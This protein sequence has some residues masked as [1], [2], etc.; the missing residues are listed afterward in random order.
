[1][2]GQQDGEHSAGD[3]PCRRTTDAT[4]IDMRLLPTAALLVALITASP[5]GAQVVQGLVVDD[6]TNR[7]IPGVEVTLV[8]DLLV[9]VSVVRTDTLGRFTIRYRPGKYY[10]LGRRIGYRATTTP[11]FA[12]QREE[13]LYLQIRLSVSAQLLA[14]MGIYGSIFEKPEVLK[15]FEQRL[16]QRTFGRF[17]TAAEIEQRGP[18]RIEDLLVEVP[19]IS[20]S[21]DSTSEPQ[22][23]FGRSALA[24]IAQRCQPAWYIDGR[25][26]RSDMEK[27]ALGSNIPQ[28]IRFLVPS[29]LHGLEVYSGISGVPAE[30]AGQSLCGTV[31]LWTKRGK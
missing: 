6:S 9:G 27:Y 3:P 4:H 5:G 14:P 13:T 23:T 10:L 12:L 16:K 28:I 7:P 19:G 11:N 8:D 18:L 2:R 29:D 31:L 17:F 1:M 22:V 30:Y 26:L 21:L 24:T 20:I 25:R 15:G